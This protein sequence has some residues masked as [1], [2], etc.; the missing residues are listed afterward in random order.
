MSGVKSAWAGAA[1]LRSD[2]R[3]RLGRALLASLLAHVLLLSWPLP[4]SPG[5]GPGAPRPAASTLRVSLDLIAEANAKPVREDS[6]PANTAVPPALGAGP[7][8]EA[9]PGA[10][11]AQDAIALHGYYPAARL[12]RMPVG[13]GSFD[14][15]PPAGGDTG[16]GGKLTL[17]VWISA[18]GGIDSLRVL[19]SGLPAAYEQAALAAFGKMRF[20]PGEIEGVPVQSWVDVVIEYADFRS[21]APPPA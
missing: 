3:F 17:R 2:R 13:I 7:G 16:I 5:G 4:L 19:A 14:I 9:P 12:S 6:A 11:G 8:Q 20:A 15:Q 1:E 21:V 18:Q 10:R